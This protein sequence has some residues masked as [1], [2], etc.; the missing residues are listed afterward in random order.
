MTDLLIS[1]IITGSAVTY[2]VEFLDLITTGF[3]GVKT[4][5]KFVTL[6]FSCGALYLVGVHDIKLVIAT[7][8]ATLVAILI[9]RFLNRPVVTQASRLRNLQ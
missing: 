8:S 1:I 7:P 6:P 3:F 9:S 5:N 2:A 4:L